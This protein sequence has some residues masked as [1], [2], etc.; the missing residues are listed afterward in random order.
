MGLL[1]KKIKIICSFSGYSTNIRINEHHNHLKAA[2]INSNIS[3]YW[4][5]P[6]TKGAQLQNKVEYTDLS[7]HLPFLLYAPFTPLSLQ[8]SIFYS[9]LSERDLSAIMWL[10]G[11][12]E[13]ALSTAQ[14][15]KLPTIDPA[16]CASWSVQSCFD[17]FS[18]GKEMNFS[19]SSHHSASAIPQPNKRPEN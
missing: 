4:N 19:A 5:E 2:R 14:P 7:R 11:S 17:F 10:T 13:T 8:F 6:E 18:S 16:A 3:K 9:S 12:D 1:F 15:C